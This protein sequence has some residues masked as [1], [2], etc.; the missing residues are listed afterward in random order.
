M[1]LQTAKEEER[2]ATATQKADD[3]CATPV[4]TD[5]GA[6][7]QVA[8]DCIYIYLDAQIAHLTSIPC[9]V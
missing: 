5:E 8:A 1:L 9:P 2:E 4:V 7:E 3:C 6:A